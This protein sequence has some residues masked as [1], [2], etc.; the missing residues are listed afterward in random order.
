M[1][2]H[3]D[4]KG[5]S[6]TQFN[7]RGKN[8]VVTQISREEGEDFTKENSKKMYFGGVHPSTSLETIKSYFSNFGPVSFYSLMAKPASNG[9]RFGFVIFEERRSLEI[10][11]Q[12]A[13]VEIDGCTV[14]V[15]EYQNNYQN[16]SKKQSKYPID[17]VEEPQAS[18]GKSTG[19]SHPQKTPSIFKPNS[20]VPRAMLKIGAYDELKNPQC[21]ANW[22]GGS[23]I[24]TSKNRYL[25]NGQKPLDHRSGNIRF[26]VKLP[27]SSCFATSH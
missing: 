3:G 13:K 22:Q 19:Q 21:L 17:A 16:S 15:S 18:C 11:L 25:F 4:C 20:I 9:T 10:V 23:E 5:G 8:F 1:K 14:F 2:F 27:H 24:S 12:Q 7:F 6:P 26:N